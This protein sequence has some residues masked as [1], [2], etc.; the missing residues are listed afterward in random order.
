MRRVYGASSLALATA[1]WGTFG[2]IVFAQQ[3]S[4][5]Q[6]QDAVIIVTGTRIP[7][8]DLNAGSPIVSVPRATI[9]EHGALEL[10]DFLNTLPQVSPDFTRTS[11]NPGDGTA[12]VNLRSLGPARSLVLLNGRR[13][14]SPDTGTG[15][16]LNSI[17]EAVLERVDVVTG[18]ASTV[19]GS[20]AIAGV[21]NFI[22]RRD[23]E[24]LD[25]GV[26]SDIYGAGDGRVNDEHVAWGT[27]ALHGRAHLL[28]Y[29]DNLEREPV[30]QGDRAFTRFVIGDS[31]KTG[32]LFQSGSIATP[33]GVIDVDGDPSDAFIFDPPGAIRPFQNPEDNY[34]FAPDNYLQ[35]PLERLSAGAFGNFELG[36]HTEASFE[37]M[38]ANPR[39]DSQLAPV[40][41]SSFINVPINAP[42]F[43]AA[44]R[45]FL[46]DNF[47]PDADGIAHFRIRRRLS[48]ADPRLDSRERNYW[49]SVVG[50]DGRL[51]DWDWQFSYSLDRNHTND[52]VEHNASRSRL[53]QG[54]MVDPAG[55]C[56]DPSN[57]C[58]AVNI[59]G[60]GQM[61]D[62]AVD[63]IRISSISNFTTTEQQVATASITGAPFDLPA[64]PLHISLGAE[65]RRV[66]SDF[67][68]DP[69]FFTG[70][71]LGFSPQEP[72]HGAFEVREI[73]GEALAPVL[74][75]AAFA[76]ELNF[77]TGARF[78][79]HSSA[80]DS[81]SWKYGLQWRPI[82][83]IRFRTMVQRAVRAPN[84]A[85]LDTQTSISLGS[86]S[87]LSDFCAASNDPVGSGLADVCVAQGMSPAAIGVFDPHH[88]YFVDVISG[89]NPNLTPEIADTLTA[90]VEWQSHG[91]IIAHASLDYARI[92]LR[93]AIE[94]FGG[95]F[96]VDECAISANAQSPPC[97]LISRDPSGA[98]VSITSIPINFAKAIIESVDVDFRVEL[99]APHWASIGPDAELSLD[100]RASH[101]LQNAAALSPNEPLFDC[102]GFFA[103]GSY[104]LQGVVTPATTAV[105]S[106]NYRTGPFEALLRW[107]WI[108]G[109]DNVATKAAQFYGNPP[110]VLAIPHIGAINYVD[111]AVQYDI[112][113]SARLRAGVDNIL[114]TR[115]PLMASDQVQANTDPSRYDVLGRRFFMAIDLRFQ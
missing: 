21:V 102:T 77:E 14:A 112:N 48:E 13:L 97:R 7:R 104:D 18:G 109:V 12:R 24:G 76:E 28:A 87:P 26:Q 31:K 98:V 103:C 4:S 61:S 78:T 41:L 93:D 16:D 2:E 64:G 72:V 59:F 88:N 46:S 38:Y 52:R 23:F 50:L 54:V 96:V 39:V 15:V 10:E 55:H 81:W 108:D 25:L 34:N 42:F 56:L 82:H 106:L 36:S 90:G 73:F 58:V 85:E 11:N 66:Q 74:S 68:P 29:V 99:P 22:T 101:Y 35:M 75:N 43:D 83:D 20:D 40:P 33:Q 57:G 6:S 107:R 111:L 47:D 89:G 84:I 17:P 67:N 62:A 115:A 63:F 91:P 92:K 49:R 32:T 44:T 86:L 80:G 70:D 114:E 95:G 110:P 51:A 94:N 100:V 5:D 105:A 37:L 8:P 53:L 45:Q 19:Y 27:S 113:A 3:S 30:R 71:V 60:E 1:C 9:E 79:D 65:W 69:A